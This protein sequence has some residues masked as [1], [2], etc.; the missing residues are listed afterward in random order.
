MFK[1]S[2]WR[3]LLQ[4]SFWYLTPKLCSD[5]SG[6]AAQR[7]LWPPRSRGFLITQNDAPE[8]VG[9]LWMSDQLVAETS[10]WQLT[11]NTTNT[12]APGEIRTYD[13]SRRA[14]LDLR[15]R[16]RVHWDRLCSDKLRKSVG[17][18]ASRTQTASD[19]FAQRSSAAGYSTVLK[20]M[21]PEWCL[22][23]RLELPIASSRSGPPT[24]GD[25]NA[26]WNSL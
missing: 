9:L 2:R 26:C 21:N 13:C 23:V 20:Y 18:R 4:I 15:L 12:H 7:G 16:P 25:T 5:F 24:R 6:S 14:A 22:C 11:T 3:R 17:F 8:S 19:G 10:T 1:L